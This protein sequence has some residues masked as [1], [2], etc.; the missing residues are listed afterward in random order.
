VDL[1]TARRA[2]GVDPSAAWPDVRAAYLR[3]VRQH[4][5]DGASDAADAG[6]RTI[7]TAELTEAY[8]A[9]RTAGWAPDPSPSRDPYVA[10]ANVRDVFDDSRR[11]LLDASAPDAFAA[12]L[13][14]FHMI[15]VV[16]YVD[17]EST[18][19]EAI[20]TPAPGQATSL[21]AFLEPVTDDDDLAWDAEVTAAVLGVEPLGSHAPAPLD[22][23]VDEIARLLAMPR[24]ASPDDETP[25]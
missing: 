8:A 19:L 13:E 2:L 12:L 3:L 15:G 25:R 24:P 16:S 17:R 21:L 4:H 11:V 14:V 9:L 7:R 20:V 10:P 1:G 23:L 6:L 5:P 18:V 22:P